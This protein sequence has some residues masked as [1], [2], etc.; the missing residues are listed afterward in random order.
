MGIGN[1]GKG[2]IR[3]VDTNSGKAQVLIGWKRLLQMPRFTHYPLSISRL[4]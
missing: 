2:K 1:T 3:T 4:S